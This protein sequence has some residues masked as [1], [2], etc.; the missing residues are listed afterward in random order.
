MGGSKLFFSVL[1]LFLVIPFSHGLECQYTEIASSERKV[2]SVYDINT[3]QLIGIEDDIAFEGVDNPPNSTFFNIIN[4]F[5]VALTVGLSY[6]YVYREPYTVQE[7]VFVE[8]TVE[9]P[10]LD[11]VTISQKLIGFPTDFRIL[12]ESIIFEFLDNNFVFVGFEFIEKTTEVCAD[13]VGVPCL[14][15]GASCSTGFECGGGFCIGGICSNQLVCYNN[16][17]ECNPLTE[18]QCPDNTKCVSRASLPVGAKPIC[19]IEE[20]E[21]GF[22]GS[23]GFCSKRDGEICSSAQ[24][25]SGGYCVSGK[26]N[27]FPM[28]YNYDC[29]CNPLTELQCP[30]NTRCVLKSFLAI[31]A[32]PVCS[33]EE[34]TTSYVDEETGLCAV[35]LPPTLN[36]DVPLPPA[37]GAVPLPSVNG[38]IPTDSVRDSTLTY[39]I[40]GFALIFAVIAAFAIFGFLK[41][42]GEKS[43]SESKLSRLKFKLKSDEAL[44]KSHGLLKARKKYRPKKRKSK[45]KTKAERE[46]MHAEITEQTA[47]AVKKQERVVAKQAAILRVRKAMLKKE[48][49]QD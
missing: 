28:C 9:L 14:N 25:C 5:N 20:C 43:A 8:E 36:N 3:N 23:D 27:S 26:C 7:T 35:P 1:F 32:R 29:E 24:E 31:G 15:D 33:S 47:R 39:V 10:A 38:N 44:L 21:T 34:C 2:M 41:A 18:L 12:P 11:S 17:C 22:V 46:K 4:P 30:D 37:N 6:N 13:C 40:V 19:L 16:D 42:E 48:K 49:R 45:A